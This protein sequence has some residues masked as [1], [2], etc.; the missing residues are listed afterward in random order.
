MSLNDEFA[1]LLFVSFNRNV[2][3]AELTVSNSHCWWEAPT[4]VNIGIDFRKYN[5]C[6]CW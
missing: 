4:Y 6:Q 3:A 5:A 2:I 1:M